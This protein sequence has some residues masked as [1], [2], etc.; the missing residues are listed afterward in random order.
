V[1]SLLAIEHHAGEE[2][3]PVRVADLN[4]GHLRFALAILGHE[5]PAFLVNAAAAVAR[6]AALVHQCD[7][8]TGGEGSEPTRSR[9][10]P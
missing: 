3:V 7:G 5:Q 9:A 1:A 2:H 4:G 6:D 10:S 8:S